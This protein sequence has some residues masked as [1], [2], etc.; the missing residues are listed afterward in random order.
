MISKIF[1]KKIAEHWAVEDDGI[2]VP[3]DE[4]KE[5][6][7]A[8]DITEED[9]L[10]FADIDNDEIDDILADLGLDDL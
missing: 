2:I 9:L 10:L 1:W 4:D 5:R 3:D 8:K 7:K 6:K